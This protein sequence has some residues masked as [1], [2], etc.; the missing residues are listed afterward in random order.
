M[1]LRLTSRNVQDAPP[2]DDNRTHVDALEG[3]HD[4]RSP[5]GSQDHPS[6]T[7]DSGSKK[8]VVAADLA[9]DW[10]LQEI[11]QQARLGTTATGAFIGVARARKLVCQAACGSNA[12]EFVAY[13]NRDRRVL[14]FCLGADAP[15][16]CRDSET[17]EE[18]DASACRYLGARSIVIVPILDDTEE[19]L[20][21]FG[22]FSPQVDAFSN[23]SIVALQ[24]LSRR[25]GDVMAQIDRCT[26]VS[27]SDASAQRQSEP[28]RSETR[29]S[30]PIRDRLFRRSTRP[31]R[32]MRGPALWAISILTVFLLGGWILSRAISQRTMHT[33]A[34]GSAAAAA[35]AAPLLS[36]EPSLGPTSSDDAGTNAGKNPELRPV[37]TKSPV[38]K[39]P[40]VKADA[41]PMMEATS[42]AAGK[43]T[44]TRPS[45]GVPD[46]EIENNLDDASSG[47]DPLPS[48]PVAQPGVRRPSTIGTTGEAGKKVTATEVASSATQ[49]Q[50]SSSSEPPAPKAVPLTGDP[51]LPS[52]LP[53][54]QSNDSVPNASSANGGPQPEPLVILPEETAL[55]RVSEQVTPDYPDEARSQHVQ[56]KVTL[57]VVVGKTGQVERVTPVDGDP[58]L[59][60]SAAKAVAKWRFTPLPRSGHFVKF[61]SHITVQVAP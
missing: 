55:Q 39:T 6:R 33:S 17:T 27:A 56:G 10:V 54:S 42:H 23:A 25:I 30:L 46:L 48:V 36:T 22:V 60:A 52:A 45:T 11:L 40:L 2:P 38:T 12:G 4:E 32:A 37:I 47:Q 49:G 28:R 21:I 34:N 3:R 58:R 15:Q 8:K 26:S 5:R 53:S 19:K 59:Q 31:L 57:D 9:L 35:P 1:G 16:R 44:S 29:K 20:G 24:S 50:A 13:L 61:E 41:K 18:F 43:K 7:R 51:R 14:D